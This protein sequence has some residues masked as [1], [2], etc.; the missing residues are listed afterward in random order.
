[1]L[2][3]VL[4]RTKHNLRIFSQKRNSIFF[5]VS[6]SK[7]P[8]MVILTYIML[9]SLNS[10]FHKHMLCVQTCQQEH[11]NECFSVLKHFLHILQSYF[12][13]Q[14][15]RRHLISVLTEFIFLQWGYFMACPNNNICFPSKKNLLIYLSWSYV[16]FPSLNF[17]KLILVAIFFQSKKQLLRIFYKLYF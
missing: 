3:C 11:G 9:A 16:L 10:Q 17:I 7:Y 14:A 5:S 8:F 13:Y 2:S 6:S 1:M 15:Y 12:P 4:A